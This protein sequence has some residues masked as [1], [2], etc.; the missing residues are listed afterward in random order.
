M[1]SKI[2]VALGLKNQ[3]KLHSVTLPIHFLF[4]LST[5]LFLS[6]AKSHSLARKHL[7]FIKHKK[8]LQREFFFS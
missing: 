8:N 3:V 7:Q 1:E 6:P 2:V 5:R 4:I